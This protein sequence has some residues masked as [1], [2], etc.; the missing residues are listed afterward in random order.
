MANDMLLFLLIVPIQV[1]EENGSIRPEKVVGN[2][3]VL[4]LLLLLY[5]YLS[6][7]F[8]GLALLICLVCDLLQSPENDNPFIGVL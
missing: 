5:A 6:S 7:L 2:K 3:Q 4:M 8:P 1:K